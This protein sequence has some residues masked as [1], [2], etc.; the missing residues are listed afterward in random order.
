MKVNGSEGPNHDDLVRPEQASACI[1]RMRIGDIGMKRCAG[2]SL[3]LEDGPAD[4]FVRR[5]FSG[6]SWT[7]GKHD[8]SAAKGGADELFGIGL[9]RVEEDVLNVEIG[10][11]AHLTARV[12]DW[13][14][15]HLLD[16]PGSH[17]PLFEI[18]DAQAP[19]PIHADGVK[20]L[21]DSVDGSWREREMSR[22]VTD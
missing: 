12:T 3:A 6:R 10:V 8:A 5:L 1:F 22:G 11:K 7:L 19:M 4:P 21:C 13:L 20:F 9:G 15:R 2:E 17:N 14:G 18:A 16:G